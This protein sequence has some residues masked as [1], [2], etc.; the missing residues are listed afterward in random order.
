MMRCRA[1]DPADIER[2]I[3]LGL[4]RDD[5][6]AQSS[7]AEIERTLPD[8]E[9]LAVNEALERLHASGVLC[10]NGEKVCAATPASCLKGG[11]A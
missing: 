2:A 10:L 8:V 11:E 9:P 1:A 3:L 5:S 6:H 7:R 4:T